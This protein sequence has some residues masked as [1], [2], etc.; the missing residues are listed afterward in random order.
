MKLPGYLW[1]HKERV[2][3]VYIYFFLISDVNQSC[4][5]DIFLIDKL[6]CSLVVRPLDTRYRWNPVRPRTGMRNSP[7]ILITTKLHVFVKEYC[8]IFVSIIHF[9]YN[10]NS[11]KVGMPL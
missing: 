7:D 5:R 4:Y 9:I 3:D 10:L 6:T 8:F 1:N 11:K 2:E